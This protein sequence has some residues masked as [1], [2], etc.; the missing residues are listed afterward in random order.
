MINK[1]KIK[2][3]NKQNLQVNITKNI[4]NCNDINLIVYKLGGLNIYTQ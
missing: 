3:K 4:V 2:K 1:I